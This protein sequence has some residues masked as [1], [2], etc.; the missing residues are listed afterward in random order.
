MPVEACP[1][2]TFQALRTGAVAAD[3]TGRG[4]L[5]VSGPDAA[6]LLHGLVTNDVLALRPGAGCHAA[7]LTPKGKL[8]A[9]MAVLRTSEDELLLDCEPALAAPLAGIL[10]GYVPFSRS[11]LAELTGETAVLQLE[12]PAAAGVLA[13][14]GLPEPPAPAYSHVEASIEGS[15]VRVARVSRA[16]EPGFALLAPRAAAGRLLDLLVAH[17]AERRGAELLEAGR[18][19]AGLPRWG[20]ELDEAVLP[21]EAWLERTA[22]S[23]TKGCYLGQETVA[24]L[25]TYGHVNRHLVALL[26]PLGSSVVPGAAVRAGEE[27][28]GKVTSAVDS[29]WRGRRVA[30]AYVRREHEAPGTLLT[31]ETEAGAVE[32][33][34]AAVPLAR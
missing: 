5:S 24:R 10:S 20:A 14:A 18:I 25:R 31:A 15:A 21:N 19:E 23:Y 34:V 29:P 30:L 9:E 16:G 7:L 26:F 22:I 27:T 4:V 13:R 28:V 11:A 12:G 17:G 1:D 8:R 32:G 3:L 2:T 33:S 6:K